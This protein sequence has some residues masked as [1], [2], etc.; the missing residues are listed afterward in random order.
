MPTTLLDVK[1][2]TVAFGD[3][4]VVDKISFKL[5]KGK[6]FALVGESGSGKSLTALSILRLLPINARLNADSIIF[7]DQELLNVSELDFCKLRGKQIGLIFQDPMSSLNPVMTISEQI[8]EV[9]TIHF[10]LSKLD[11]KARVLELLQQVEI[12]EP[13]RRMT[14]Y[15]HQLSGG[16]R[17]RV[18]IAIAL[19]AKPDL[20]IADEPTTALDVT[21]QA[22][23]LQLLKNIQQQ[24]E[25]ALWLISHDLAL[26]S[27]IADEVTV[28][29]EGKIVEYA[30][31]QQLFNHPQHAYNKKLLAALPSL[32]NCLQEAR[33][34]EKV[35]LKVSDFKVYY[36]IQKGL[37]KRVVDYV[38]AVDGV[39]FELERGKTLALVGE[40]GC[41]KTT[42]G[43]A[44]LNLIPPTE[45]E[46]LL[47]GVAIGSLTGEALRKKRA[48]LQIVF[49]DPFAAMNPRM[50]VGEIIAEGIKALHPKKTPDE[51]DAKVKDLLKKVELPEDSALRYPHE[52]SGGQRQRICIARALAVEPKLIVCDEPTSALDVSVQAQI[53]TLLKT[54]QTQHGLSYLFITHDLAVVAEI[55]DE[56]AVMYQGKIVEQGFVK[57]ILKNPQ[58]IYSKKLL[59]AVPE[60][61]EEF[62]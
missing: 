47:E 50:L 9:L 37:F 13:E 51:T 5:T 40:S 36:P 53:L 52:F 41:G 4:T 56:I 39:N 32:E 20:L 33:K 45:G 23:I 14:E 24:T 10:S 17:Q 11:V 62:S 1:N 28:M 29:Q 31:S 60:L 34:K 12:P 3:N 58:H 30:S 44:L 43:K 7:Q 42:L 55:A 26:V 8:A 19:A 6:T 27:N 2:L 15:P 16:Q 22:Q 38:R 49:Q 46:V 57:Q 48:E 21:I 18:M 61:K 59:S 25:M 35:L 54:L